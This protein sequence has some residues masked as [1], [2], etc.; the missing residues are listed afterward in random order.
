MSNVN[1]FSMGN[2]F[3]SQISTSEA[4]KAY[5]IYDHSA[6]RQVM[7]PFIKAFK[8][9]AKTIAEILPN[10]TSPQDHLGKPDGSKN[11]FDAINYAVLL[12][13]SIDATINV[14][15][16]KTLL[17]STQGVTGLTYGSIKGVK[18]GIQMV[19]VVQNEVIIGRAVSNVDVV[20]SGCSLYNYN[21]NVVSFG[22]GDGN[23]V[24][25]SDESAGD[26]SGEGGTG[27]DNQDDGG[28]ND[29]CTSN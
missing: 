11:G 2:V 21:Y 17:H 26:D 20:D 13:V 5:A 24:P 6:W 4:I 14:Y 9:N 23:A 8:G 12:P 7:G 1:G 15:T 18:V 22:A 25:S 29:S 3:D 10:T 16:G 28:H 27:A 19:E